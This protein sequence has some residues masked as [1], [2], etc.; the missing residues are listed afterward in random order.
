MKCLK[1]ETLIW[2]QD[3][4]HEACECKSACVHMGMS[5]VCIFSWYVEVC[6][7]VMS[8]YVIVCR[9]PSMFVS[10]YL[11]VAL[12]VKNRDVHKFLKGVLWG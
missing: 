9:Q 2:F 11:Y 6:F 3:T 5:H 7:C 4:D 1:A 12:C 8:G 10:A